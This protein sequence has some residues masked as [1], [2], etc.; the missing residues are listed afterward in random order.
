M[1]VNFIGYQKGI[2]YLKSLN[3]EELKKFIITGNNPL[4]K[5]KRICIYDEDENYFKK[6]HHGIIIRKEE[7]KLM[8]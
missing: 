2:E 8:D 3:V 7:N 4:D 1:C 6:Y 5:F